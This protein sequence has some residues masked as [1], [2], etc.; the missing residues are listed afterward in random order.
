MTEK[1]AEDVKKL[2]NS[3]LSYEKEDIS[4]DTWVINS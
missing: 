2:M 1:F 4:F 3:L